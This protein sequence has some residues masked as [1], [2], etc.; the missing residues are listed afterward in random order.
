MDVFVSRYIRYKHTLR[1]IPVFH[2]QCVV[3]CVAGM[4]VRQHKLT[5]LGEAQEH[6]SE[7][8]EEV[9]SHGN[10][11]MTNFKPIFW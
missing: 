10:R 7:G 1:N 9:R 3:I 11:A 6:M 5:T 8:E 4:S 2:L